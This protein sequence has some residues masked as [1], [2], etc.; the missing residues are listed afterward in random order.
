MKSILII[1]DIVL[2]LK[3]NNRMGELVSILIQAEYYTR[4]WST[5]VGGYD[6]TP[7][8]ITPTI[9]IETINLN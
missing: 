3:D 9:T 6:I 5:K 7:A 2:S 1:G 8:I 4:A